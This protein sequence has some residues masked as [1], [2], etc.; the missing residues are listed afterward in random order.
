MQNPSQVDVS[1]KYGAPMGRRSNNY[2]EAP[3]TLSNVV[4]DSGGY[5]EGGAYWGVGQQLWVAWD[6]IGNADYFRASTQNDARQILADRYDLKDGDVTFKEQ[7][8]KRYWLNAYCQGC[9]TITSFPSDVPDS[10]TCDCGEYIYKDV[11]VDEID[12]VRPI[13]G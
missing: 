12:E 13:T 5:D 8:W 6:E 4:I 11:E 3:V 1:S 9:Q 10:G 7:T 2:L